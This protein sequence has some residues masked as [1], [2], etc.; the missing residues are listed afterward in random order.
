MLL[1]GHKFIQSKRFYHIYDIDMITK[2]PPSSEIYLKFSEKNLDII[3]Y[4]QLNNIS[5]ALSVET[6][7]ELIFASSLGASYIVVKKEDAKTAQTIAESYLFDAK[8]L[9]HIKEDEEIEE[10]A[11]LGIDGLL[12]PE[13]IVK[14][15]S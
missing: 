4:L 15:T 12:F 11:L 13:A 5:F 7:T 1:F 2:T 8:I 14:L 10:M 3:E 6:V 9:V